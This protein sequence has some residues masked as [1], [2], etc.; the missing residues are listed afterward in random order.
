MP[1][2]DTARIVGELPRTIQ[3]ALAPLRKCAMGVAVGA[4]GAIVLFTLAGYHALVGGDAPYD[5]RFV[6]LIGN[7]FMPGYKPTLPGALLGLPYGFAAGFG[8]GWLLALARNRLISLWIFFVAA[9]ERAR[10]HA[11]VLDDLN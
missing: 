3:P 8:F 2:P 10:I 4:V 9:R 6:W 1:L 5:D 7:N 11:D